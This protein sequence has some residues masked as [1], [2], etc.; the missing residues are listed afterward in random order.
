MKIIHF[1]FGA[2][3][4]F[5]H[6]SWPVRFLIELFVSFLIIK[7]IIW[8]LKKLVHKSRLDILM[9]KGWVW[10]VTEIVFLIGHGKNW[11]IEVDNKMIE[12]GENAI[13][14]KN[15]KKRSAWKKFI[16]VGVII[17]YLS[18]IFVDLPFADGL[19]A[20]YLTELTKMKVFCQKYEQTMSGNYQQYPPLFIA[21]EPEPRE[22]EIAVSELD[23]ENEPVYIQLNEKGKN[24]SNIRKEPLMSGAIVGGV[25]G[26]SEIIY[27]QQYENDGE[28]YWIKVYLP[29]DEVEGWLSGN[30]VE[31]EQIESII[32]ETGK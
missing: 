31:S 22:N 25:N 7:G 6:L 11:A 24:G 5:Y 12:W 3:Q 32:M 1:Y 15:I 21:K 4:N 16:F 14:N 30:L 10:L 26:K 29:A 9:I 18:A 27:Q 20:Y 13:N 8:L 28:R 19:E 2:W 17:L 23:S